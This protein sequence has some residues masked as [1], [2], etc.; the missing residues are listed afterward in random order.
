MHQLKHG[1]IQIKVA[2]LGK[3]W[4]RNSAIF[5]SQNHCN[6]EDEFCFLNDSPLQARRRLQAWLSQVTSANN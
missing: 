3:I 1:H 5:T 4:K 6:Y 2:T